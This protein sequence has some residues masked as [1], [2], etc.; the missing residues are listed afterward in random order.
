MR[1]IATVFGAFALSFALA[2]CGGGDS[3]NT[4]QTGIGGTANV[5]GGSANNSL[6]T[7]P[8]VARQDGTGTGMNDR[9]LA[10]ASECFELV[11]EFRV[12]NGRAPLTWDAPTAGVAA[13]HTVYMRDQN[14]L[15]HAGPGACTI[16]S[17]C[18]KNRLDTGGVAHLAAGENVA[19]R[20]YTAQDAVNAWI[21]SPSHRDNMLD[22]RWTAVGIGYAEGT[23][24]WWT[25]VFIQR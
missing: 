18:L 2:A 8:T 4:L 3:D 23:D 6:A 20:A 11:N 12:N 22:A 9:Q 10:F 16:A 25:Q 1:Q 15:T 17:V 24:P 13:L 14:T 7:T 21:A 19:T 5:G